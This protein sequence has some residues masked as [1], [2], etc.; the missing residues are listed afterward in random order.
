MI[1]HLIC[2]LLLLTSGSAAAHAESK[3]QPIGTVSALE[4]AALVTSD[5]ADIGTPV[6][7]NDLIE[8]DDDARLQIE[9]VDGTELTLGE[10]AIVTIDEYTY[11][12]VLCSARS[13]LLRERFDRGAGT[14]QDFL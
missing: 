8:T 13:F 7:V 2:A 3:G 14:S 10:K 12:A 4:G 9:F 11:S 6:H 1:K 5:K